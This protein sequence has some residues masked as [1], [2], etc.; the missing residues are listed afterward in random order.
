MKK[1]NLLKGRLQEVVTIQRLASTLE[2]VSSLKIAQTKNK[3]IQ[4]RECF[5]ELWKTYAALR[6]NPEKHKRFGSNGRHRFSN[7]KTLYVVIT[8]AG[9]LSGTIDQKIVEVLIAARESSQAD[10]VCIGGHGA[11]LLKQR[12]MEVS[13]TFKFPNPSDQAALQEM[14]QFIG[15]Y[16]KITVYYQSYVSLNRQTVRA[17]DLISIVAS[18]GSEM[19]PGTEI[20]SSR[21]FVFEP[22]LAE[23]IKI[24]ESTMLL[25]ALREVLLD[26]ELA[27]QASRF[28]AMLAAEEKAKKSRRQISSAWHKALRDERDNQQREASLVGD[29]L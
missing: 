19:D 20:I 18:I 12:G 4:G 17:I 26:S 11:A 1:S 8:S 16:A 6:V 14:S 13:K 27:Q 25:I 21:A 10:I 9:G 24:M 22:S 3:V 23:I 15:A 28:V 2:S 5:E 7:G 29:M